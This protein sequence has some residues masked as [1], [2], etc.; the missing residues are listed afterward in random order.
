MVNEILESR[1]NGIIDQIDIYL[2]MNEVNGKLSKQQLQHLY[3]LTYN[4][5]INVGED[6]K[7]EVDKV[8][9]QNKFKLKKKLQ[10]NLYI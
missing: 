2:N 1:R 3:D 8:L 10:N 6:W 7:K 9:K 4:Y 5:C